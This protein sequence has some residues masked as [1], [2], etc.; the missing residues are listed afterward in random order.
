MRILGVGVAAHLLRDAVIATAELVE[1]K[2]IRH[3]PPRYGYPHGFTYVSDGLCEGIEISGNELLF[4]DWT[5]VRYAWELANVQ[6]LTEPVPARGKQ[7]LWDWRS[8]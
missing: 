5:P 3:A 4:G 8:D 6:M 1:C 7:G 2:D